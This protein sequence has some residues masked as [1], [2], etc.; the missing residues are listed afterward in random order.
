MRRMIRLDNSCICIV[1]IFFRY[2][3]VFFFVSYRV[4]MFYKNSHIFLSIH[5]VLR[6][7]YFVTHS[8]FIRIIS[9]FCYFLVPCLIHIQ[10]VFSIIKSTSL[11][12]DNMV[13]N[14]FQIW[15][16]LGMWAILISLSFP[17]HPIPLHWYDQWI[18]D[19]IFERKNLL[20]LFI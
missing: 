9:Y 18:Q 1:F 11:L 5:A 15:Q 4:L 3:I 19:L 20:F 13:G 16:V 10:I 6:Y 14:P 7:S 17:F 2:R 12:S 8:F